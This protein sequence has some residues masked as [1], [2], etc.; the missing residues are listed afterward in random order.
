MCIVFFPYVTE[1][2]RESLERLVLLNREGGKVN[3]WQIK[4]LV[5]FSVSPTAFG[6]SLQQNGLSRLQ[7][8]WVTLPFVCNYL[9]FRT[10]QDFSCWETLSMY[11]KP[12][13]WWCQRSGLFQ[14]SYEQDLNMTEKSIYIWASIACK[15]N[16]SSCP[17]QIATQ[18][19]KIIGA[20]LFFQNGIRVHQHL[21]KDHGQRP[22][23]IDLLPPDIW[24]IPVFPCGWHPG[25]PRG[26][27]YQT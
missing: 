8:L 21:H 1:S 7:R 2:Y 14:R 17:F 10:I 9:I 12:V 22:G 26:R 5:R 25:P 3:E 23:P 18:I 24:P 27:T 20:P 11:I 16:S 15:G 4:V 6:E 19:V 13:L